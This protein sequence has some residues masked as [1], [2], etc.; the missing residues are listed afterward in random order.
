[1]GDSTRSRSDRAVDAAL[2]EYPWLE[3]V[4]HIGWVAKGV[5]YIVMGLTA[6]QIA[7]QDN[8]N[9]DASPEGSL[10]RV[11]SVPF[12]RVL[13]AVLAVGIVLYIVERLISLALLRGNELSTWASR[14]GHAFSASVFATLA[15]S[16]GNAAWNGGRPGSSNSVERLSRAAL[17]MPGGRWLLGIAGLVTIGISVGFIVQRGVQRSFTEH[18]DGIDD[19]I[20][21]NSDEPAIDIGIVTAGVIGWIGRGLVTL[22][23]GY[24]VLSAAIRFDPDDA[25]GFDQSLR[26]IAGTG[27]GS[28]LVGLCAVGLVAFGVFCLLSHRHRTLRDGSD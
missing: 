4:A 9:D 3:Q 6:L 28:V 2:D 17:E 25:R 21:A 20:A 5:V 27:L 8:T 14:I 15:W 18:L 11:A 13:L 7:L 1:M 16:A 23:V 19:D 10:G 22:L 12:G 24:F 26:R